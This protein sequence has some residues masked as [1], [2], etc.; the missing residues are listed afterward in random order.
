MRNM[1]KELN[2]SVTLTRR[3]RLKQ[4]IDE[5]YGGKQAAFV[6]SV[7]INQGELSGLLRN[8][9]FGEKRARS[10]EQQA[11][12]PHKWLDGAD[13]PLPVYNLR[14]EE[15]ATLRRF[16][17]RLQNRDLDPSTERTAL[18]NLKHFA[19]QPVST[20]RTDVTTDTGMSK[21][22]N[23]KKVRAIA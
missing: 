20:Y 18:Q 2:D 19:E 7:E 22:H 9:H 10:L 17:E 1:S 5:H 3:Q 21:E 12:M 6:A 13:S 15:I 14:E 8:K 16:V 11:G 4:W 23:A